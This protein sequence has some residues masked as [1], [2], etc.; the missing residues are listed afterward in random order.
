MLDIG[1]TARPEPEVRVSK[2]SRRCSWLGNFRGL[3]RADWGSKAVEPWDLP[4]D[5][6]NRCEVIVR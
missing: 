5:V 6:E 4:L 1:L 3:G 2:D